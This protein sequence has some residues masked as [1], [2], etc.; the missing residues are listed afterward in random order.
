M[1]SASMG[2]AG[3]QGKEGKC[4]QPDGAGRGSPGRTRARVGVDDNQGKH[5]VFYGI[6]VGER[7][8]HRFYLGLT[9]GANFHPVVAGSKGE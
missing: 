6:E 5:P 2:L 3:S 9:L 7:I 8:A 1:C 4:T